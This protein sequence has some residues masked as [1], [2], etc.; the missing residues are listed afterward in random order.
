MQNNTSTLDLQSIA[1]Q[2]STWRSNKQ[3]SKESMPD[4]LKALI[5]QLVPIYDI[6]DISNALRIKRDTIKYF[7]KIFATINEHKNKNISFTPVQLSSLFAAH[8]NSS[9]NNY[10][11]INP[12]VSATLECQIIKADGTKLI[13][14]THNTS[15]LIK[16]FLCSN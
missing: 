5:A 14:H 15:E 13:V 1:K 9:I 8:D 16:A 6:H 10:N 2:V 11:T 4:Q 3:S 7:Y 12:R